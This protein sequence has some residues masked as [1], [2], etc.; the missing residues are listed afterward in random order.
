MSVRTSVRRSVCAAVSAS[1]LLVTGLAA[2]LDS[3]SATPPASPL[4]LHAP[5]SETVYAYHNR[6]FDGLIVQLEAMDQAFEI[7]SHRANYH[8]PIT[9]QWR[10]GSTVTDLP[11]GLMDDFSGLS[12]FLDVSIQNSAGRIALHRVATVCLNGFSTYRAVPD[13]A[14]HSLYP[15]DCPGNIF[16][17]GSVQGIASGWASDIP[18]FGYNTIRLVPGHYSMRITV[19]PLYRKLFG[20]SLADGRRTVGLTVKN[21]KDGGGTPVPASPRARTGPTP[22]RP[23]RPMRAAPVSGPRPDLAALPA[24]GMSLSARTGRYLNFA[25]DGVERR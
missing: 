12:R 17:R 23:V 2:S 1:A 25:G 4:T 24:W 9:S 8:S 7:W 21:A 20:I 14:A 19:T 5:R 18:L 13:G 3:A 11:A 15:Y 22:R 16:A 6:V 10:H